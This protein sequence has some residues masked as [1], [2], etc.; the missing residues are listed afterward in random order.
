MNRYVCIHGHFYQPP[1]EN[2][3]LEEVEQED[4]ARPYH[5]WNQRVTADSY[6][7]NA[8]SRI[9]G[10]A[11][12]IV[13][14]VNNYSKIS[15]NFGPTLLSW[16]QRHAADVYG[17]IIE[18]DRLGREVFSGHGP[19]IAQP[20]NHIIMPLAVSRDK[21]TQVI[22]GIRDFEHRFGRAPEGMWLPET[23]VDLETL[24][25]LA[26]QGIKFTI[27]APHQAA[28]VRRIGAPRWE[29]AEGR[30]IDTTQA[31]LCQLPSGRTISLFFYNHTVAYAVS[32]EGLLKS[33]EDFA[34]RLTGIFA[35]KQQD[36]QLA[37]IATD[38]ETYGHHHRYGDMALAYCLRYV[39]TKQLA[40]LTVYGEFL[41]KYPAAY[42][43]Q[44]TENTS[45]SC[46][47]GLE[48]WRNDCGCRTGRPP[49]GRQQW[50][51][52]LREAMDWLRDKL[53]D[54]YQQKMQQYVQDVW[55]VRDRYIDVILNRQPENIEKFISENAPTGLSQTE[56]VVFLK[57]LEI[58]R[59]AML[60]YTSCG[61]FF[62]DI[63]GLESVQVMQYAARAAQL[64]KEV[65]AVDLEPEYV[66]I[67]RKAPANLAQ[68][69]DGA[70]VYLSYAKGASVDLHRV[71][72][73]YALSSL[74]EDYPQQADVHCYSATR[75]AFEKIEAGIQSLAM[76]QVALRSKITLEDYCV[77]FAVLHFGDHNLSGVICGCLPQ[78]QFQQVRSKLKKTFLGGET[79]EVVR[80]M[81]E[82]IGG[83]NYSLKHLFRDQQQQI[84]NK[85]LRTRWEEIVTAFRYIYDSN[86]TIIRAMREMGV[87][88]P[89]AL[90]VPA[91]FVLVQDLLGVI[92]NEHI[93]LEKLQTLVEEIKNLS[94]DLDQATLSFEA[95]KAIT[96]LMEHLTRTP[97]DTD[98]LLTIEAVIK[99]LSLLTEQINLQSAQNSFFSLGRNVYPQMQT[100][101]GQGDEKAKIWLDGFGKLAERLRVKIA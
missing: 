89:K 67:L 70:Q 41:E 80:L 13:D 15:F 35:D 38:G 61:W 36:G 34:A 4:S 51:K 76:G 8:A 56:Q 9:L 90:T 16:L 48:R 32:Y 31:Y 88:L 10:E 44:I 37:H 5:D 2:P 81:G 92:N 19:A 78:Q 52:P 54:I 97:Q 74:F 101:A 85:L 47:H 99:N 64:V 96:R 63:S 53:A 50:R 1:R 12:K 17:A 87:M 26:E 3:W 83:Q 59:H 28:Q 84:L 11:K 42:E 30:K 40:Q 57:L 14:I 65:A 55:V 33:G 93:D 20:Y 25:I 66:E 72:A 91:E 18:A 6:R 98:L 49:T 60:M 100:E 39:E 21:H 68:Y 95:D 45:W 46:P 43:V 71:G 69:A 27:L 86:Y 94:L 73:H 58:Q 22:W 7:P 23:A 77:H 82:C 24:D 29:S 79:A 75:Q 62:D